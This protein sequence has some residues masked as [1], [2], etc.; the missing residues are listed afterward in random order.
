VGVLRPVAG[1]DRLLVQHGDLRFAGEI[2]GFPPP[3]SRGTL[4]GAMAQV[5]QD[6]AA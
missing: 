2:A 3:D 6:A 1:Q 5:G 4:T